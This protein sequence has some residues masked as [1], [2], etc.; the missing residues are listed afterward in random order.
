MSTY[1]F[2]VVKYIQLVCIVVMQ[3]ENAGNFDGNITKTCFI[4]SL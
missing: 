2:T 3:N 1:H 4:N